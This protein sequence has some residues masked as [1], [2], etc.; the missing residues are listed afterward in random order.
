[1][2]ITAADGEAQVWHPDVRFFNIKDTVTGK[3]TRILC[4]LRLY[5]CV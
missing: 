3:G 1:V 4:E 2:T 5:V